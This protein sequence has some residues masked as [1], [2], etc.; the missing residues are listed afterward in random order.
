MQKHTQLSPKNDVR[1]EFVELNC[2]T[3]CRVFSAP[4][5]FVNP[6][7][8]RFWPSGDVVIGAPKSQIHRVLFALPNFPDFIAT[9]TMRP[10]NGGW[11][12]HDEIELK[13]DPWRVT[14]SNTPDVKDRVVFLR[15]N[16]GYAITAIGELSRSDGLDFTFSEADS[17]LEALR[18][19]LSFACGRW[20]GPILQTGVDASGR[21][22]CQR[23][24]LPLIDPGISVNTWF[25][26]HHGQCLAEILP[27]F[28]KRWNNPVWKQAI[29]QA[30]YWFVRANHNA[31]GADGS[32][33]LSQAALESLSWTYL[34][35]DT[36]ILNRQ[37]FKRL[38]AAGAMRKL[39]LELHIP[40]SVPDTLTCLQHEVAARQW[41]DGSG[42]IAAIRNNLVHPEKRG[43][44][45]P[46]AECWV[47]AQRLLE[48]SLLRLFDF[49]GVHGNRTI[50]PRWAGQVELVPWQRK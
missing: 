30:I 44:V 17:F 12:R 7:R 33:I 27:G 34:V 29:S 47:L 18:V 38:R 20:T 31:A 11:T 23:W 22:V 46:I 16:G 6:S 32:L 45:G 43:A 3:L 26:V 36:A 39:L 49:H 15:E 13:L 28:I 5:F 21:R 50:L 14:I 25:D 40:A 9:G 8:A 1:L 10:S 35:K 2:S 19:F 24:A 4:L 41:Q 42:A 37:A 48:L